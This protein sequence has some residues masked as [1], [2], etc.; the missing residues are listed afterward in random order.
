MRTL[1]PHRRP[2]IG[3]TTHVKDQGQCGSC[4]A[5]STIEGIEFADYMAQGVLEFL[6][7]QQIILCD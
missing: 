4:W 1:L 6:A 7:V 3:A 2:S 5:Y